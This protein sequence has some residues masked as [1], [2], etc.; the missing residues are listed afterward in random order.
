[1]RN[2]EPAKRKLSGFSPLNSRGWIDSS[3][4]EQKIN[5]DAFFSGQPP[6]RVR[7]R[8]AHGVLLI[9]T[10]SDTQEL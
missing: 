3:V 4:L 7:C 2:E 1:M 8:A 6:E 5:C 9:R 10:V